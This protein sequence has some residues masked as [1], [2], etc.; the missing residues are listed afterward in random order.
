MKRK[1]DK[2]II[3]ISLFFVLIDQIVKLVV[4]NNM[5]LNQS[6]VV[7]NNFFSISYVR[8]IGAAFGLFA[9]KQILLIIVTMIFIYF[10]IDYI[11][12]IKKKDVFKIIYFSMILSGAIGNLI[13]RI[14]RGFVIDYLDFKLLFY[15]FPVFNLADILIVVGMLLFLLEIIIKG[16]IND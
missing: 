11:L 8:N 6:I 4:I 16:D 13:D 3:V 15:D 12:K 14:F 5:N 9:G 2:L 1:A 7:I 10:L